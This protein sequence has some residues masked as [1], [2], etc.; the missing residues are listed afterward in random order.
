LA[1]ALAQHLGGRIVVWCPMPAKKAAKNALC[2]R[3]LQARIIAQAKLAP[4][5]MLLH[6]K[7]MQTCTA[8]QPEKQIVEAVATKVPTP[9]VLGVESGFWGVEP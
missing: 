5:P 6:S 9:S 4:L 8:Q 3:K 7:V 1:Q 2:R